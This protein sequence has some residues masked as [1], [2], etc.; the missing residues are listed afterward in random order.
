MTALK[1]LGGW[2]LDIEY[3][4]ALRRLL[5][6]QLAWVGTVVIALQLQSMFSFERL[7]VLWYFGFIVSVHLFAPSDPAS[8]WWRSVQI[9]VVLGFIGLSYFVLAQAIEVLSL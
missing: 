4:G 8:R 9:I 5:L 6:V 1:T 7:F 2:T 3:S